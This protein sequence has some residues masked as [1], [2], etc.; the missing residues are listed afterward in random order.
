MFRWSAKFGEFPAG[1][2]ELH[3]AVGELY[4]EGTVKFSW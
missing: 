4:A 2:P 1:D 3:E